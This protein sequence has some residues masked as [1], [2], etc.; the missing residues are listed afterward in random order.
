MTE[1]E[2]L[3][4]GGDSRAEPGARMDVSGGGTRG[5]PGPLWLQLRGCEA[6]C[7]EPAGMVSWNRRWDPCLRGL[8]RK[9]P[10]VLSTVDGNI[11]IN[12]TTSI[13]TANSFN[14]C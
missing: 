12:S 8:V 11:L 10:G 6:G 5:V 9:W 13:H 14:T 4:Q 7:G 3:T 2:C 1:W